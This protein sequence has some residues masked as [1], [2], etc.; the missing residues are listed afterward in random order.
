MKIRELIERL[1]DFDGDLE[2]GFATSPD[3]NLE[4]ASVYADE[5]SKVWIDLEDS[6]P[7]AQRAGQAARA[8]QLGIVD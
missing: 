5:R 6:D 4:L 7:E 2:L 3:S 8:M 1:S